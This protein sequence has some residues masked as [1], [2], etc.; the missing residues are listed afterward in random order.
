MTKRIIAYILIAIISITSIVIPDVAQA[1]TPGRNIVLRGFG[2]GS[3]SGGSV[4]TGQWNENMQG[5]RITIINHYGMPAFE[6]E[7]RDHLDIIFNTD[8]LGTV[9]HFMDGCKTGPITSVSPHLDGLNSYVI[10]LSNL[11]KMLDN[12]NYDTVSQA[13]SDANNK[14]L[15]HNM[16]MPLKGNNGWYVQGE[17]IHEHFNGIERD[18]QEGINAHINTILNIYVTKSDGSVEYLWKPK[19]ALTSNSVGYAN[20]TY[21]NPVHGWVN[22]PNTQSANALLSRKTN[23]IEL[24]QLMNQTSGAGGVTAHDLEMLKLNHSEPGSKTPVEIINDK[25]YGV[26]M[27]PII[28]NRLRKDYNTSNDWT[29]YVVYGTQDN[30]AVFLENYAAAGYL[31]YSRYT[32][33]YGGADTVLFGR[34]GRKSMWLTTN[35]GIPRRLDDVNGQLTL[36]E[37]GLSIQMPPQDKVKIRK[38]SLTNVSNNEMARN[39]GWSLH[40]F[41]G[42]PGDSPYT[43]T[44]DYPLVGIPH[45]APD[46]GNIP[47]RNGEDP[48]DRVV[49]IIKTYEINGNHEVTYE[50]KYN[51]RMIGIV[52]E[53]EY[54]VKEWFIS[55][56]YVPTVQETTWEEIKNNSTETIGGN[57]ENTVLVENP[58]TSLY[59]RLVYEVPVVQGQAN[60]EIT[61]SQ[62]TKAIETIDSNIPGWGRQTLNFSYS[63]LNGTCGYS[64]TCSSEDCSGHTCGAAY[65]MKDSKHEF[66]FKNVAIIRD[67]LQANVGVF[68]ALHY[69]YNGVA[70]TR[71]LDAGTYGVDD[72]S[73]QMVLWRGKDVPTIAG[74]KESST[75]E[76]N[77]LLNRYGK[78][79]AGNRL[80]TGYIDNL[81]VSL[82]KDGSIGDY[83]TESGHHSGYG[84]TSTAVSDNT[85]DYSG[86]VSI[87]TYNG[88]PHDIGD[89]TAT[90]PNSLFA[91]L[92]GKSVTPKFSGGTKVPTSTQIKFYPYIRM[93]YQ[94]PAADDDDRIDVNV[95]SQWVSE[96]HPSSYAEA[97]WGSTK[98]LNMNIA[99]AQWSTHQRAVVGSDGWQGS[100]KVLPGGSIFTLD[101]KNQNTYAS[102]ITWQPYL[103]DEI[104][105]NVIT[106]GGSSYKLSNTVAPH[107]NLVDSAEKALD[108]W[109]VVQYV[110]KNTKASNAFGGL[111]VEAGGQSLSSLGLTGKSSTDDKYY[112]K[113]AG[114]GEVAG[115]GDLD[116]VDTTYTEI[117]YKVSANTEGDV[118][119]HRKR[120]SSGWV[121]IDTIKKNEGIEVLS[122]ESKALDDR[123]KVVTNLLT[124]LTRNE[125]NDKTA[126][127]ATSDGKWYNEAFDG[128]CYVRRETSFEVGFLDSP[129]RS[130]ALDPNL[131]PVNKGQSDLF[132]TAFIS[133]F[134]LNDKSDAYTSEAPGYVGKFK[135]QNVILP[136]AENMYK[137][138]VFSIPN[139]NVQDLN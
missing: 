34:A 74:Y 76:L 85:L 19:E 63:D 94:L 102:V 64:W 123:T 32:W 8:R 126:S 44:L 115:Q 81:F 95:L 14:R 52:D 22:S 31:P 12:K 10:T 106:A 57:G 28:W 119:V 117:H 11:Q 78:Q 135:G 69:P 54:K 4:G 127:W 97:T 3:G 66:R 136:G 129:I 61:E 42:K 110:D 84:K 83:F 29:N 43:F 112:Y 113:P 121:L 96:L 2:G 92:V 99:S 109:R 41:L 56:D 122:T 107:D 116:I 59:V 25:N 36:S 105:N 72:F 39:I 35:M 80:N 23:M 24:E 40:M 37:D 71:G 133:Q 131:T 15:F 21:Y 120:G 111:K 27:E 33:K 118:K 6:F 30:I 53:V 100:N 13:G 73:Y 91:T 139:V 20:T 49:N 138:R 1:S 104:A 90:N 46:P 62:I 114:Q 75:H 125:G 48:S 9:T 82:D 137:T 7:G 77:T 50:R 65:T 128:I 93:T 89:A 86:S 68:K 103:E 16:P 98:D 87:K 58:D 55:E 17:E 88:K 38:D 26:L 45:P 134:R 5:I 101:T 60:L 51:P 108:N 79:P 18:G 47:L 132:S 130:A 124:V 67:R 70:H